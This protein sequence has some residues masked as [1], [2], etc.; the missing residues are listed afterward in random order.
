MPLQK[1]Q[2]VVLKS[3][4]QGETSKI[5]TLYTRSFGK[6]AVIAKG[7]RSTR[8][9]FGG[10]LEPLNYISIVFYEKEN[11]DLQFL[12]QADIIE[13][14]PKIKHN[15]E[16]TTVAMAACELVNQLEIGVSPNT[17][18]FDLLLKCLGGINLA[19][20]TPKNYL[21]AFEV[22]LFE[23]IGF[24]PNLQTCMRCNQARFEEIIFDLSQ[25]GYYC[26]R[27]AKTR[28]AGM[29]LNRESGHA[30]RVFQQTSFSGLNGVLPSG[31]A[32]Q[33]VDD[34]LLSYF[35]YHVDG[36]KELK[37]LKFLKQVFET[38]SASNFR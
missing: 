37:S 31:L 24:K 8:S 30:L 18:L 11:R 25:G 4:K 35:R 15:L 6:L 10:S 36:F 14:F 27:C 29:L 19:G 38:S 21:R 17:V 5:L 22:Q 26:E 1:T 33:Q 28:T 34:F 12:S 9:R 16:K 13:A 3:I 20:G 32:R 7:A 23:L 2:A